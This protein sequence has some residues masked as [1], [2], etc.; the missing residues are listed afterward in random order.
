MKQNKQIK[1][2]PRPDRVWSYFKLEMRPLALVTVSG[3]VYNIGMIAGPYFEGKLAQCLYDITKGTKGVGAMVSLAILYLAVI[4]VVQVMRAVK[5]FYVRRFANNTSRNMRHMLYNS[6]VNRSTRGLEE[7]NVGEI[8]TKAISD[9]DA[10]VEGMRKF[11]T[12]VFDTGVVLIAYIAMLLYYDW[13]LTLLAGIFTPAAYLIAG[14]LKSSVTRYNSLYKKSA[15]RLNAATMDRISNAITYRVYGCEENR[16]RTY[17]NH[18]KD[19]EKRAVAANLWE[20]SMQPIYNIISMCGAVMIVYVGAKNVMGDGWTSWDIAAFT[21]FLSCF[22]KMALKSS[23]A[24]KLFNA[25]QKAEVS[26]KRVKP[27]MKEYIK[28]DRKSNPLSDKAA[29]VKVSHVTIRKPDGIPIL[30]DL[31]FSGQAG[32][33]IGVTGAVACGKSTLGRVFIGEVPYEGSIQIQGKELS[34]FS[35]YERSHVI[36]Y[37]G[38]EPELMSDSIQENIKLGDTRDCMPYLNM[39]CLDQEIKEMPK[40]ENTFVGNGGARLSGGQQARLALARTLYHAKDILVLDD[41][42]SAVDR[43]TE[44]EI[45]KYLR[46]LAKHKIVILITH[47][48]YLFP[49][50]D[51]V[52][53]LENGS[54]IFGNHEKL[55]EENAVYKKLYESQAGGEKN[56]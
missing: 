51:Q 4:L 26:W 49:E 50:L 43:G 10:C 9:V 54:G 2:I 35:E 8:M 33:I 23:K 44:Q 31:S 32:Q 39:V 36:S 47:R 13:R 41:P 27:L 37:M 46:M 53:F 19:Y 42:F 40:K 17:E 6:L 7:E 15:G 45:F 14:R 24:A 12:E 56:A 3:I 18:L 52:L 55:I 11:T 20:S 1:V 48:L 34:S 29:D 5:R 25:V 16:D 21:T 22:T 38:H 28:P 30:T